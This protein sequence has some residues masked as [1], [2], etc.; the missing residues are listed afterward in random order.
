MSLEKKFL[1]LIKKVPQNK[2][3]LQSDLSACVEERFNGF[4]IVSKLTEN[5]K[6]RIA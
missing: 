3:V 1:Y 5:E 2:N 4:E 6:G